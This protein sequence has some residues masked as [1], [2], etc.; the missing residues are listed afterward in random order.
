MSYIV[1]PFL[2][3]LGAFALE[4]LYRLYKDRKNRK[5]LKENLKNELEVG[6]SRLI[7][8]GMLLPTKMWNSAVTSGDLK[9]VSFPERTQLSSIY[10]EIENYNYEAKR[11]RDSAVVAQTGSRRVIV[12]GMTPAMAYWRNLSKAL[13]EE[14]ETLKQS[15]SEF[16]KDPLWR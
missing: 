12:D 11:V 14:E 5:K 7:G 6:M 9:I 15:I 1:G 13:L 4:R 2:G 10:C 8:K 16:L 3:I